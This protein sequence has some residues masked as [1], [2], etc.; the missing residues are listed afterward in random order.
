MVMKLQTISYFCKDGFKNI[1]LNKTMA[2][3]SISIVVAALTIVGIFIG[4]GLNLNYFALQIEKTVDIRAIVQKGQE[5]QVPVIEDF[6]RK[7]ALI[8]EYKFISADE[9][10]KD[11]KKK[12]GKNSFLLDG[13][14][15]DNPL[16][17]YFIIKPTKIEYS[18]QIAK[19]LQDIKAIAEVY[20]PSQTVDRLKRIVK[21]LNIVCTSLIVGLY[22]IAIFIISNT[23]KIT[24]YARRREISIMRYIGATNRFIS[25]PFIV[26]GFIIGII[27]AIIAYAFVLLIYSYST[28][29]LSEAITFVEFVNLLIY[30]EK[31]FATFI[32]T[33][34]FI[35]V[36]G[37][38]ISLRRYLR[39]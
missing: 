2:A 22:I 18:Q 38:L 4:I 39:A 8:A 14:E 31:I 11:L 32:F 7:N 20:Y 6:L 26:E 5:D 3:A 12:L 10:L 1:F 23:I 25:G 21:I 15:N 17:C 37:S 24:L 28:K 33:G 19:E 13:L 34:G 29:Y 35:G 36:I 27:G 16:R 9:A 30:K